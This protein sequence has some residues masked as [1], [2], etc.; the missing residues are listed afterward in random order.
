[1]AF[2]DLLSFLQPQL[3]HLYE[4]TTSEGI[5]MTNTGDPRGCKLQQ[6]EG[7]FTRAHTPA[8]RVSVWPAM[9][10]EMAGL[11]E[12]AGCES[13]GRAKPHGLA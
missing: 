5:G 4:E 8:V 13:W 11:G 3:T 1:M 10:M 12:G 9:G 6:A 7:M 2:D